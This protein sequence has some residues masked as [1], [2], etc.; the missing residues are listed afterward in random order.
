[1]TDR[2]QIGLFC[3][4]LDSDRERIGERLRAL[5][6][7]TLSVLH[8]LRGTKLK[9]PRIEQISSDFETGVKRGRRHCK[10]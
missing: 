7:C 3:E 1:M 4:T 8:W 10:T 9:K 6:E 2:V 5:E